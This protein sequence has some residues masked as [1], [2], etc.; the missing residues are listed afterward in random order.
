M[1]S[2]RGSYS[3][4]PPLR[5]VSTASLTIVELPFRVGTDLLA[6]GEFRSTTSS[7]PGTATFL[8]VT[9]AHVIL[10]LRA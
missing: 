6:V 4:W 10:R 1:G 3:V 8:S 5:C 7:P 9:L 2:Y